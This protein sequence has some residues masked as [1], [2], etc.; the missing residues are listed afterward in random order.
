MWAYIAVKAIELLQAQQTGNMS[1][2]PLSAQNI[3]DCAGQA[4][5]CKNQ[6]PQA[7]FDY[8]MDLHLESVYKERILHK[9]FDPLRVCDD[10]ASDTTVG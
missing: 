4:A 8:G 7:A 5:A 9:I 10:F 3:I 6:N 1:P 2:L